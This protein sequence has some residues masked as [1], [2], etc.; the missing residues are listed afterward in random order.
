MKNWGD[1]SNDFTF[2]F[3]DLY[4][5]NLEKSQNISMLI[6]RFIEVKQICK[7]LFLRGV[8]EF[9]DYSLI[10]TEKSYAAF[11]NSGIRVSSPEYLNELLQW[12]DEQ[13][14]SK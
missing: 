1:Q 2:R 12:H 9:D 7:S 8:E 10:L 3:S 5:T 6:R 11:T 13:G 14:I 4:V